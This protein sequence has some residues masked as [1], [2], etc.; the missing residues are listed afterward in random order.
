MCHTLTPGQQFATSYGIVQVV[1]DNRETPKEP[2]IE[3]KTQQKRKQRNRNNARS[4]IAEK[5][6]KRLATV[7]VTTWT[8]REYL[9]RLYKTTIP[10]LSEDNK[11][12]G[13]GDE[14]PPSSAT[15]NNNTMTSLNVWHAYFD[16]DPAQRPLPKKYRAIPHTSKLM[17]GP[18]IFTS[19]A[20]DRIVE[21]ILI[22][23]ERRKLYSIQDGAK[24]DGEE[25]DN[26]SWVSTI[27]AKIPSSNTENTP[28]DKTGT[29]STTPPQPHCSMRLFLKRRLLVTPYIPYSP[30]YVCR[31]CGQKFTSR[32]GLA[33]HIKC[34]VCVKK[35][36]ARE[37]QIRNNLA[38]IQERVERRI[39]RHDTV[40]KLKQ[41]HGSDADDDADG[42]DSDDNNGKQ[43]QEEISNDIMKGSAM[44]P[45]VYEALGYSSNKTST[46]TKTAVPP[47]IIAATTVAMLSSKVAPTKTTK[48]KK[49]AKK[50]KRSKTS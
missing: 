42:D 38:G 26:K 47:N 44:Y 32:D 9:A 7:A 43:Q 41:E 36:E 1:Q 15:A 18:H 10:S 20:P 3:E 39:K 35:A 27:D 34:K 21:C 5:I 49:K 8:R 48:K 30:I 24:E 4:K 23:D 6:R 2:S 14:T 13:G 17:E 12:G 11:D 25:E 46:A 28:D 31:D 29:R 19:S 45:E 22:R 40:Q 33:Y 37:E 16:K 50:N